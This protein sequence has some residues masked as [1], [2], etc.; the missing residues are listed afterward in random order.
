M[1]CGCA[2]CLCDC[3]RVLNRL[4]YHHFY[5]SKVWSKARTK[6]YNTCWRLAKATQTYEPFEC[7]Q[8]Y[9]ARFVYTSC[10]THDVRTIDELMRSTSNRWRSREVQR[11]LRLFQL[12]WIRCQMSLELC[13]RLQ[14]LKDI[15]PTTHFAQQQ[16]HN[17]LTLMNNFSCWKPRILF[18]RTNA[19]RRDVS[20][21]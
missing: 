5:G 11:G 8:G 20:A 3:L 4:K 7:P 6:Q 2:S 16:L 14:D 12:V 13:A 21:N 10:T 19:L 18:F 1:V 15:L 9:D 17:Y